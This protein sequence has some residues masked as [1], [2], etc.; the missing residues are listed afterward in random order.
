V[1][2]FEWKHHVLPC[3]GKSAKRL[4]PNTY[5]HTMLR[6]HSHVV[7]KHRLFAYRQWSKNELQI[8]KKESDWSGLTLSNKQSFCENS[9]DSHFL[10]HFAYFGFSW[11][12]KRLNR[13]FYC[14]FS[15]N[16]SWAIFSEPNH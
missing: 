11:R 16:F 13:I 6:V 5:R 9:S 7:L 1:R 3:S 2:L 15:E 10:S 4:Q 14:L 8:T 12:R